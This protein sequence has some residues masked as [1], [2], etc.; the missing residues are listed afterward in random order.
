MDHSDLTD[1]SVQLTL[2]L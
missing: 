2:N 1:F